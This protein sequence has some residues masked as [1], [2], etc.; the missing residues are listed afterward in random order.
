MPLRPEVRKF[1]NAA[2]RRNRKLLIEALGNKCAMC[3]REHRAINQAHLSHDP[4]DGTRVALLCPSCH[5][6]YDTRQ[7]VAM[8][9]RTRAKR[10]GQLWL[11]AEIQWAP[12]PAWMIPARVLKAAQTEMFE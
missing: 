8:T 3:S 12:F 7:R 4:K 10:A 6:R 5:S 11:S 9:R 1:Y 2:W